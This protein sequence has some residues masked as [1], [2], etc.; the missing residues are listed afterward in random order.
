MAKT[1][2][3]VCTLNDRSTNTLKDLLF[4]Y[5]PFCPGQLNEPPTLLEV[6]SMDKMGGGYENGSNPFVGH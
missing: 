5:Q 6:V 2:V 1:T 3:V 4:R